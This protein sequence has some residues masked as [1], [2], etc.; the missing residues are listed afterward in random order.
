MRFAVENWSPDY[1]VAA[2]PTALDDARGEVDVA[3]ERRYPYWAPRPVSHGGPMSVAFVDGVRRIDARVWIVEG[4]SVRPAVCASVA[5]GA[6]FDVTGSY[7]A[8]IVGCIALSGVAIW[9]STRVQRR[10]RASY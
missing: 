9:A 1:G 6:V 8:V 7:G 2:D 10:Q 4:E 3:R 5:A